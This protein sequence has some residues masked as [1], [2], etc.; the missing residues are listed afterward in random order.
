MEVMDRFNLVK[1]IPE[2]GIVIA[3]SQKGRAAII[4]LTRF[5]DKFF[6]RI[7]WIVPFSHQE[8]FGDRPFRQL[9]GMDVSPLQGF[10]LPNDVPYI[11]LSLEGLGRFAFKFK[12]SFRDDN[13]SDYDD[14]EE[15]EIDHDEQEDH[16]NSNLNQTSQFHS[17]SHSTIENN[18]ENE[19]ENEIHPH[20]PSPTT[21]TSK[22]KPQNANPKNTI[23]H[24]PSLQQPQQQQLHTLP[25][26]HAQ[27]SRIYKP[28]ESW[29]SWYSSRRY[30][31]FLLYDDHT[32]MSYEFWYDHGSCLDGGFDENECESECEN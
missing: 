32:V 5:R 16:S 2:H 15:E 29:R 22:P 21:T 26:Y 8:D 17:H 3:A 25:E 30:R 28:H 9:L 4:A 10:E 11:P 1:Y 20:H 7:D 13:G 19:N 6:F 24:N 12:V 31:L 18:E 14:D 27:A 23:N